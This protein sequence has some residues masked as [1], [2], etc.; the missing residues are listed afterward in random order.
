MTE[1]RRKEIA[2]LLIE[3]YAIEHGIPGEYSLRRQAGEVC[4][5]INSRTDGQG[6]G[7]TLKELMVFFW[8]LSPIVLSNVF[9]YD[10]S[11]TAKSGQGV[12]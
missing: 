12:G 2:L 1:E 7:V 4:E 11:V 6:A 9:N 5:H 3:Q 10:V 8:T